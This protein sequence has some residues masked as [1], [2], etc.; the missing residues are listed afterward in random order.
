MAETR[1]FMTIILFSNQL[2]SLA[3]VYWHSL[4]DFGRATLI[5]SSLGSGTEFPKPL[6]SRLHGTMCLGPK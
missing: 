2:F 1:S 3:S 4:I 6:V 5:F